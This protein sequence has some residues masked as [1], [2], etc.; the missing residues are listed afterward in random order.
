M[1]VWLGGYDANSEG[2]PSNHTSSEGI[3]VWASG[4]GTFPNPK[5]AWLASRANAFVG[6]VTNQDYSNWYVLERSQQ[7]VEHNCLGMRA[8]DGKWVSERYSITSTTQGRP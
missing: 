5:V 6:T 8:T 2:G 4:A 7:S 3:W 1:I